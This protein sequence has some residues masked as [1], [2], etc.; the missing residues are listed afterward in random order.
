MKYKVR[1]GSL[2]TRLMERTYIVTA[3]NETEAFEKASE[4]LR[5][6][7]DKAK[8]YTECNSVELDFIEKFEG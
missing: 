5:A 3:K 8:K 4:R 6:D 1:V 7:C 2:V